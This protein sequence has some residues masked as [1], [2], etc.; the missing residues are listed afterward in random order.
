MR[1]GNFHQKSRDEEVER[2]MNAPQMY[3]L[4]APFAP[5]MTSPVVCRNSTTNLLTL[6]AAPH[7][8]YPNE[9]HLNLCV[10]RTQ[11]TNAGCGKCLGLAKS[12]T[13]DSWDS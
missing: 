1:D 8:V 4:L 5:L 11:H 12:G 6:R 7:E 2:L 3:F 10:A 9:S 13:K